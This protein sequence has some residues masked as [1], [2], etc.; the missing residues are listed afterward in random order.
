MEKNLGQD[1]DGDKIKTNNMI[2][3]IKLT[4]QE[5]ESQIINGIRPC[6]KDT[7]CVKSIVSNTIK[8][9]FNWERRGGVLTITSPSVVITF[10]E[11][12]TFEWKS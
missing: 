3:E 11:T 1:G 10:G 4:N 7:E 2:E 9:N 5:K 12:V 6:G 8:E